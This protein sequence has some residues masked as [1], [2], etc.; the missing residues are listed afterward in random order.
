MYK[1]VYAV[2]KKCICTSLHV[3]AGGIN[4]VRVHKTAMYS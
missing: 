3:Y 1:E 4:L 2:K